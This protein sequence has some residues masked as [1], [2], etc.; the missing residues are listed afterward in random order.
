M[1]NNNQLF[2]QK[3]LKK[4][5]HLTNWSEAKSNTLADAIATNLKRIPELKNYINEKNSENESKIFFELGRYLKY[6]RF[7]KRK[8]IKHAYD[9]DNYFYMIF[10]GNIAKID[11]K[12]TRAYVTFKEYLIHLIK[13]KLLGENYVYKKCL[14][15]N[16]KIFP[17]NENIDVL[18]TKDINIDHYNDLIQKIKNDIENSSWYQDE[19]EVNNI[20]DFIELYNPNLSENKL[21][22]LGKE[23]KYPAFLPIYNFDKILKPISFI[24]E[25]TKPKGI[26]LLSS[27]VCLTSCSVFYINKSEIETKNNLYTLFRKK[28][29]EDVIKN[30]FE[31]HFLFQDIDINFLSKYYSKYFYFQNF[32][33][34]QKI[35]EQNTPNQGI[36]LINK[37]SFQL[38]SKRTYHELNELKFK[39]MQSLDA[40]NKNSLTDIGNTS[41]KNYDNIYEGLNPVQIENLTKERDINFNVYQFSDVVGLSDI[42]DIKT[43][44]NNFSVECISDEGDA[45]FLPKEIFTSMCTNEKIKNNI[46][47]LIGKHCIILLREINRNKKIFENY[48]RN[49]TNKNKEKHSSIFYLKKNITDKYN[50]MH[51]I[52]P[53]NLSLDNSSSL[54]HYNNIHTY[55]NTNLSNQYIKNNKINSLKSLVLS[56]KKTPKLNVLHNISRRILSSNKEIKTQLKL[57]TNDNNK[58][59]LKLSE[60]NDKKNENSQNL[61]KINPILTFREKLKTMKFF[62]EENKNSIKTNNEFKSLNTKLELNNILNNRSKVNNLFKK[63]IGKKRILKNIII[64]ES[65]NTLKSMKINQSPKSAIKIIDNKKI[66]LK[67]N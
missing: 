66:Y 12:Y 27:Y 1:E 42:Y 60:S 63:K 14:K 19:Q 57:K 34:G 22:F 48:I 36:F 21:S 25:L 50:I 15:R 67:S 51:N 3:M 44:L 28:V 58:N 54:S 49:I 5:K 55:T 47:E 35:I 37:G 31:G 64:K 30:L 61:Y 18:T 43:G 33:K 4:L 38:K 24:G 52:S 20:S 65:K 32:S 59:N 53:R 26:K 11:I 17:F 39:V 6:T 2:I 13:L 10:S 41:T 46:D 23:N 9:S 40:E 62:N 7:K 8:F 45:Y 56:N 29:S 16:K